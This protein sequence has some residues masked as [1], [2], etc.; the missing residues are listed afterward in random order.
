MF[1]RLLARS[2]AFVRQTASGRKSSRR[3]PLLRRRGLAFEGLEPRQL[4]SVGGAAVD[5][6]VTFFGLDAW[7]STDDTKLVASVG[8]ANGGRLKSPPFE[9]WFYAKAGGPAEY[10]P[11]DLILTKSGGPPLNPGQRLTLTRYIRDPVYVDNNFTNGYYIGV[12]IDPGNKLAE[13]NDHNNAVYINMVNADHLQQD[14]LWI[15]AALAGFTYGFLFTYNGAAAQHLAH[16]FDGT[17]TPVNWQPGSFASD[18]LKAGPEFAWSAERAKVFLGGKLKKS[19]KTSV[20]Y[21]TELNVP[22]KVIGKPKLQ[23]NLDLA[24]AIA[25]TQGSAGNF[26]NVRITSTERVGRRTV[27]TYEAD[28]SITYYDR[29]TFDTADA[30]KR[31]GDYARHLE[32][33]GWAKAFHVSITATTHVRGTFAL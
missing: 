5:P 30:H 15:Q 4:L 6:L 23:D 10:Q 16:W 29:Y 2:V 18:N 33:C 21:D 9:L 3:R 22:S 12:H 20:P 28:L 24:Y 26:T 17:G 25:G 19:V 7:H 8:V 13:A 32:M 31:L 14:K 27:Y 1:G 11:G